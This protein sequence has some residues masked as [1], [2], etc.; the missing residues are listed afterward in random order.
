MSSIC[1]RSI[2]KIIGA[3][4]IVDELKINHVAEHEYAYKPEKKFIKTI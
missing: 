4:R 2:S 3:K 1:A